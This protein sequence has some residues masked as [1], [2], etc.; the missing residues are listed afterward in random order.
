MD[1][2]KSAAAG[3]RVPSRDWRVHAGGI[4]AL[5]AGGPADDRRAGGGVRGGQ[6]AQA[7]IHR[8][9]SGRAGLARGARACGCTA[10]CR[11]GGCAGSSSRR[12][13][14]GSRPAPSGGR[15]SSRHR[16]ADAPSGAAASC[17][18]GA[19]AC[20]T[21]TGSS[22]GRAPGDTFAQAQ[23]ATVFLRPP[24]A[25]DFKV[26]RARQGDRRLG[27]FGTIAL[28]AAMLIE[29]RS[30][31]PGTH[32]RLGPL[33]TIGRTPDNQIVVP[34]KEVSRRHAEIVLTDGGYVVKDLARRTARSSTASG[35]PNT[36]CRKATR[37]RWAARFSSSRR[38]GHGDPRVQGRRRAG[39]RA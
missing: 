11:T 14:A 8:A 30:G 22:S 9:V 3:V 32:H 10:S 5:P 25:T 24:S 2:A 1:Q 36:V 7:A 16:A 38:L 4:P 18:I 21:R 20:A 37:S 31:L 12:P 15:A 28:S 39:A 34:I 6:E 13:S 23:G 17:E 29:D 33:T 27:A 26:P 19:A 35:S